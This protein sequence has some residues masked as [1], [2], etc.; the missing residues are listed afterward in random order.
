MAPGPAARLSPGTFS[1]A[2]GAHGDAQIVTLFEQYTGLTYGADADFVE[3]SATLGAQSAMSVFV[4]S[5]AIVLILLLEP[6]H[7]I[8]TAWAPVSTPEGPAAP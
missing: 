6:Q 3:A 1:S 2:P 8:F 7:R 4:S 5:T